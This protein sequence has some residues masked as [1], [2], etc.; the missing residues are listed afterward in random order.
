LRILILGG[1]GMLGHKLCQ[2]LSDSHEVWATTTDAGND[3]LSVTSL[4]GGRVLTGFNA[5]AWPVLTEALD[6]VRPD[7]VINAV[8]IVKQSNLMADSELA[9]A[10]NA[11][12]PQHLDRE[13]VR[14]GFRFIHL[15]TDCVFSGDRGMYSESDLPDAVDL[16]GRS[17]L[18]GETE[19]RGGLVIRTSMIG[20]ELRHSRGLLE[21]LFAQKAGPVPGFTNAYFSGLPTVVLCRTIEQILEVGADLQGCYHVASDRVSKFDLLSKISQAAGGPWE[22]VPEPNL[23]VDRSL[24]GSRFHAATGIQFAGWD[25]LIDNMLADSATSDRKG[26]HL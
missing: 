17:K 20:R 7:V 5:L 16:Y 11:T 18:L 6:R 15:S 14:R 25:A 1:A 19:L 21:W 10:V 8:G 2:V 23:Q 26:G 3:L 24:D 12:L 4:P 22:I 13:A 9:I